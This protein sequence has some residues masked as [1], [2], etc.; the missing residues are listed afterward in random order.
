MASDMS[1]MEFIHEQSGL[2]EG[3]TYKKMFGEYAV[4]LNGK[5][6]A[7][8]CDNSIFLKPTEQTKAITDSFP[9]APPYPGAKDYIV[10]DELLDKP[11]ELQRLLKAT[12]LALPMPKPKKVK[13]HL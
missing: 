6:I 8:V 5:V 1:F 10:I 2:R 7:F 3:F 4:Y 9:S 13:S 11:E 12:E